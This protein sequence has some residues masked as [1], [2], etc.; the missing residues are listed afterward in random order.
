MMK[1]LWFVSTVCLACVFSPAF[2]AE[3]LPDE[4]VPAQTK[5]LRVL[6]Y[7]IHICV[8]N[9][10][11]LDIERTARIINEQKPDIVALQEVDRKADRT[12]QTD[13]IAELGRLTGMHFAFGKTINNSNG[14]YGIGILS[15]FPIE[16]QACTQLPRQEGAEDRGVLETL[17]SVDGRPLR[18]INTHFCH[19]HEAR[20]VKQAQKI[21][22]L[23]A[24]DNVPAILCGDMNA[25]PESSTLKCLY[26]KWTDATDKNPTFPGTKEKIDYILFR[27]SGAFR[28]KETRVIEEKVASDHYPVLSVL[29]W[30]QK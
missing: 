28:V 6:T 15:K 16:K 8:G 20:R 7:N 11:T 2:S 1:L 24:G 23:F 27:P 26:E 9:D 3:K 5:T 21:N 18:F 30:N 22:E 10:R 25:Q 17:L 29:E 13:Q 19:M 4:P 14:E 12:K